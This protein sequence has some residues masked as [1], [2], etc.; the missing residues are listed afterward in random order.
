MS[1]LLYLCVC[2]CVCAKDTIALQLEPQLHPQHHVGGNMPVLSN[3][4][5]NW[6]AMLSSLL[7]CFW[8]QRCK[9]M[10][11]DKR[12][13]WVVGSVWGF[14]VPSLIRFLTWVTK[15]ISYVQIKKFVRTDGKYTAINHL[16]TPSVVYSLIYSSSSLLHI[17]TARQSTDDLE[18]VQRN[19]LEMIFQRT[20]HYCPPE[21]E[22]KHLWR[23][24]C[25][26]HGQ[27]YPWGPQNSVGTDL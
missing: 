23:E 20:D 6:L 21:I 5:F 26:V 2:V 13:K 17:T 4:G 9:E 27:F 19:L 18:S 11:Q 15:L 22:E 8:D 25:V 10:R 16:I 24:Y 3:Q 7:L 1:V 12:D 14:G